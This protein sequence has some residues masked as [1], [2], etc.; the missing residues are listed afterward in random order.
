MCVNTTYS[1]PNI[2]SGTVTT[3][4]HNTRT[5]RKY[6]KGYNYIF[7]T[8]IKLKAY[9]QQGIPHLGFVCSRASQSSLS[10]L[11][12]TVAY[13]RCASF[14][15]SWARP[16]WHSPLCL[17]LEEEEWKPKLLMGRPSPRWQLYLASQPVGGTA[18][19]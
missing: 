1:P 2:K 7:L 17:V 12:Q 14:L 8:T 9:I 16:C 6:N 15:S 13:W 3:V 5:G 18:L 19:A 4:Y 11:R 10:F